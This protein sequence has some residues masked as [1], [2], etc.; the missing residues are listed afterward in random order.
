M[1]PYS[2]AS[3]LFGGALP[4]YVREPIGIFKGPAARLVHRLDTSKALSDVLWARWPY[5]ALRRGSMFLPT[6]HQR[7]AQITVD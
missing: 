2:G 5:D 3:R 6:A 7:Q 1:L 4:N